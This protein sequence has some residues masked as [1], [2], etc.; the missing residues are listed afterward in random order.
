MLPGSRMNMVLLLQFWTAF[1]FFLN[2]KY[3]QL[4]SYSSQHY[5]EFSAIY[6]S[7]YLNWYTGFILLHQKYQPS[8][9]QSLHVQGSFQRTFPTI[10]ITCPAL[11]RW[12]PAHPSGLSSSLLL[13]FLHWTHIFW[14]SPGTISLHCISCGPVQFSSVTRSC[15]TLCNLQH[16]RPPCPSP[17]PRACS[18]SCPSSQ[19]CHPTISSSVMPFSSRLQSFPASGPFKMSQSLASGGH[20]IGVSASA[21]VL[22]MNIQDW[23]PLGWTGWISL[24]SKGL[25]RVFSNTTVQRHQFFSAQLSL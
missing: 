13:A 5:F 25:S 1:F 20:R 17:T 18:N 10:P 16:A 23:F 19:W 7:T 21:S 8:S 22:P 9:Q 24:Q 4:F 14:C 3:M 6:S 2:M 11:V 12:T 15:P